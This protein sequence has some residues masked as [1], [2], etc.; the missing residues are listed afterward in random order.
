MTR[1]RSRLGTILGSAALAAAVTLAFAW[2]T[3]TLAD[4]EDGGTAR[5]Q[6]VP[7]DGVMLSGSVVREPKSATGWSLEVD[8]DNPGN[9]EATAEV[10]SV[11]TRQISSTAARVGPRPT[12]M[13]R[14]KEKLTVPAHAKATRRYDVPASLA[15]YLTQVAKAD[16]GWRSRMERGEDY[17][18]PKLMTTFAVQFK[19]PWADPGWEN[20]E[21]YSSGK[22]GDG[23]PMA[24]PPSVPMAPPRESVF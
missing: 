9:D 17:R 24:M 10:E 1:D 5:E 12:V 14:K 22:F 8:A 6:G 23:M 20:W 13:W 21:S 4:A 7:V 3:P 16:E 19:G 2:P 15:A 18:M 11:I